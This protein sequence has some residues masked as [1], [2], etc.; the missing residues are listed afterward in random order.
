[1]AVSHVETFAYND[2]TIRVDRGDEVT[3]SGTAEKYSPLYP[4]NKVLGSIIASATGGY[5]WVSAYNSDYVEK[6][7]SLYCTLEVTVYLVSEANQRVPVLSARGAATRGGYLNEY[8]SATTGSLTFNTADITPEQKALYKYIQIGY[9]CTTSSSR[10][11][12]SR[13]GDFENGAG[14]N[15]TGTASITIRDTINVDYDGT[16]MTNLYFDG[17]EMSGLQYNGNVIF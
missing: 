7:A 1:M 12:V 13:T 3:S 9:K 10:V 2:W 14:A 11:S 4:I 16:E 5:G 15:P 8:N 17:T 6:G